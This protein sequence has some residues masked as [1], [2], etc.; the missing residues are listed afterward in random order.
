M[1]SGQWLNTFVLTSS[2]GT[3]Q[4]SIEGFT[5]L[6]LIESSGFSMERQEVSETIDKTETSILEIKLITLRV[7]QKTRESTFY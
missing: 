1:S 3:S 6:S 4:T 7:A 5:I 2:W